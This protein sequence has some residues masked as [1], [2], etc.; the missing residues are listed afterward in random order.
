MLSFEKSKKFFAENSKLLRGKV[1]E[2][3][4]FMDQP[5][6]QQPGKV[7]QKCPSTKLRSSERAPGG[8]RSL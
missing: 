7:Q 8:L 4:E 1:L 6:L 3:L 5:H 2:L